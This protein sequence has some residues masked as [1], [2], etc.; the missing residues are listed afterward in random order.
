MTPQRPTLPAL[1]SRPS[2][3]V[4][5][6]PALRVVASLASPLPLPKCVA[7]GPGGRVAAA[8][9]APEGGLVCWEPD[10]KG[11]FAVA[12]QTPLGRV[13]GVALLPGGG[14]VATVRQGAR[15]QVLQFSA[16]GEPVAAWGAP[17]EAPGKLCNPQGI[18]VAPDG[19][20]CLVEASAWDGEA[21]HTIN[22]VQV[23][24]ARG[25][26][27]ACWGQ[28][29]RQ[30]GEL[31]LP[32]GVAVGPDASLWV[33][34]TYNSRVQR[35]T[36]DGKL[37]ACWGRVGSAPGRL[38]CPQG[39]C[40]L[41]GGRVLVADTHND[42]IQ[43]FGGDGELLWA[44]GAGRG[45]GPEQLWLPCGVTADA[46]GRVWITDTMNHRLQVCEVCP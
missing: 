28:A 29:G 20:V 30:P 38:N 21:G 18:A 24:S 41:P 39:I 11:G 23:F 9:A 17:G 42:R 27:L 45:E 15:S 13:R 19:R 35:F 26:P 32:V 6:A 25:E 36:P 33:A 22:R 7:V 1:D 5:D 43:C 2:A 16:A 14:V 8:C 4:Q 46:V 10:G 3:R 37:L 34:D 44:W 31:N 40:P 12:W